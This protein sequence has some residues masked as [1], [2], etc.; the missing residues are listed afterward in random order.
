M[1]P[2]QRIL[3]TMITFTTLSF[4]SQIP[5][6]LSLIPS[7]FEDSE[8]KETCWEAANMGSCIQ[9]PHTYYQCPWTCAKHMRPKDAAWGGF[10]KTESP[11]YEF[12]WKDYQG[13]M[14][15]FEDLEGEIVV[16][17]MIP[18]YPGLAQFHYELLNHILDVYKYGVQVIIIPMKGAPEDQQ[19]LM[20]QP[21][22]NSRIRILEGINDGNHAVVRYLSKFIQ[23]GKFDWTLL[24]SFIIGPL[25]NRITLH[26]SPDI[27]TYLKFLDDEFNE[28]TKEL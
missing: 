28:M 1:I 11:F 22:P 3:F 7:H 10:E 21:T 15:D 4:L 26:I 25:G 12:R 17:A 14:I 27:K 2:R 16:V 20:I 8:S 6:V 19:G 9:D 13:K 5:Y 18:M 23:A 24:N